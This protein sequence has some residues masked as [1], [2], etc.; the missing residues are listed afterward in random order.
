MISALIMAGGKGT[1]FWPLSTE[2][3]PKQ[4]LKLIGNRTMIQKTVDRILPIIDYK[5]IFV[6]TNARYSELVQEQ[7]P[8]LPAENIILE[9]ES[10]NTMPGIALS[11]L[12]I[13]RRFRDV[14]I[15]V[16]PADHL[17]TEEES[18]RLKIKEADKFINRNRDSIIT[19]G[20]KPTR[21][22]TGYGYIKYAKQ[23]IKSVVAVESFV[24]KPNLSTAINYLESDNYL[25]NSG[26]FFW[27][28]NSILNEIKKYAPETYEALEFIDNSEEELSN[29]KIEKAY[30][31]T[32]A[33]SIDYAIMEKSN[34]IFVIESNFGWDDVGSW[35]ALTRYKE[36]D[37]Y[38]NL[39]I[40]KFIKVD[41]EDN[42]LI[43]SEQQIFVNDI[44]NIYV[45][46]NEDKVF[47]GKRENLE[48]DIKKNK[49]EVG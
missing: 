18:F 1:R 3:K 4:F 22:E 28:V 32:T 46:Q 9:P 8:D 11:S 10:K 27:N 30:M 33:E 2:E 43:S 44:S 26:M 36:P 38:G 25:W 48:I 41:G 29:E 17:I 6:C 39:K 23:E 5:N 21:P 34:N 19:F 13:K 37:N 42:I 7:L 45:I 40:G 14:N 15:L 35:Q 31:A 16:L 49:N 12:I 24:E 20:M 47:I